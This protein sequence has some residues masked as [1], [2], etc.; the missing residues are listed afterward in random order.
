MITPAA[1]AGRRL[2]DLER[3]WGIEI[4]TGDLF[5][6]SLAALLNLVQHEALTGWLSVARRGAI[7]LKKG[8]PRT[9][10][11]GPLDGIDG[12]R[13]LIF[14]RGGRFS[15]VRGEPAESD[16][17]PIG[18]TT[19]ALMD[20]YRLRDEWTRIAPMTLRAA[21][22]RPWQPTAG[23]LD[24]IAPRLDGRRTVAEAVHPGDSPITPLIDPLVRAL[25]QGLLERV[26]RPET[27]PQPAAPPPKDFYELVDLGREHMRRGEH[28]AAQTLLL[29][30]M[31]LR[32]DDR[33][34][35]QNLRALAQR[36]R[37]P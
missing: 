24:Q 37:Q 23:P 30:A 10:R 8:Q 21:G 14:H 4:L 33:V 28:E 1:S 3:P 15:L 29:Q 6:I 34:V 9:A 26:H 31:A 35:Q 2:D 5:E 17:P 25:A 22:G 36:L 16:D 12:L 11:C 19:F 7:T 20:A 13:E 32:P 18:S 27:T